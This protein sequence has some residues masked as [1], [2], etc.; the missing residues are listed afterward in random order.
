MRSGGATDTAKGLLAGALGDRH[1]LV[2]KKKKKKK[3]R[4]V[5]A[6]LP[7]LAEF[8]KKARENGKTRVWANGRATRGNAMV[9]THP[10]R[11]GGGEG[12]VG[13][14]GGGIGKEQ[15]SREKKDHAERER[16]WECSHTVPQIVR[17]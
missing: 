3:R 14:W 6:I 15:G 10:G 12:N 2:Q 1:T 4:G 7:C 17:V 13:L 16:V 8:R 9:I 11:K 5:W